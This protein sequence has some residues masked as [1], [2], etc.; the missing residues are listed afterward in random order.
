LLVVYATFTTAVTF[1]SE[2][3]LRG[4]KGNSMYFC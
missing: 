3:V 2:P 4:K 1:F